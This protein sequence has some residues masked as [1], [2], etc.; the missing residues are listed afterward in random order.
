MHLR[1][2][3]HDKLEKQWIT[4]LCAFHSG[5]NFLV[6]FTKTLTKRCSGTYPQ[7]FRTLK[8]PSCDN[9]RPQNALL[10]PFLATPLPGPIRRLV[11]SLAF[12]ALRVAM[13]GLFAIVADDASVAIDELVPD[14]S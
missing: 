14:S 13:A 12:S 11:L 4:K 10:R 1:P 5:P 9:F 7:R 6:I 3:L 2:D 8:T